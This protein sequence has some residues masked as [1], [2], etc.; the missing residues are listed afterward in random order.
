MGFLVSKPWQA[1]RE[2]LHA[3]FTA[4]D[5]GVR[6]HGGSKPFDRLRANG[7]WHRSPRL[8]PARHSKGAAGKRR[9]AARLPSP[10]TEG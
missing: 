3:Q 8:N 2:W 7:L 9:R 6:Q 5:T 4:F 10:S 1:E